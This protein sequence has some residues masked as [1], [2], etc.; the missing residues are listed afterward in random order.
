MR[1]GWFQRQ[2]A[3]YPQEDRMHM[4]LPPVDSDRELRESQRFQSASPVMFA[5]HLTGSYCDGRMLNYSRGGM[6]F[7]ADM[8]PEVG[9]ELFIGIER[10]PDSS[11]RDVF[12]ANVVWIRELP[13][14]DSY[15]TYA[16]GVKYR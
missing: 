1:T 12:R 9:A 4:E 6:C 2:L 11:R 3:A 15:Y 5:T 14:K 13:V 10:S 7:E 16:V 8:A